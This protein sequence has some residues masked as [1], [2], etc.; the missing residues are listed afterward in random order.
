MNHWAI[1]SS[2]FSLLW[3]PSSSSNSET[4]SERDPKGPRYPSILNKPA[5]AGAGPQSPEDHKALGIP[6]LP[7]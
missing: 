3:E 5:V 4:D 1:F 7:G 2:F 6:N